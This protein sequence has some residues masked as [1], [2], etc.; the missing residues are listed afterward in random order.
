VRIGCVF[1]FFLFILAWYLG[2]TSGLHT[3]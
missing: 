3:W 1:F 2:L